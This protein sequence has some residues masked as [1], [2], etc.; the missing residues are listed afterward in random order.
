MGL[1]I[2]EI[3]RLASGFCPLKVAA[4]TVD[5]SN[6]EVVY[7]VR[8][9]LQNDNSLICV[10]TL[11]ILRALVILLSARVSLAFRVLP[12]D[13]VTMLC[14][15]E[16]GVRRGLSNGRDLGVYS[17]LLCS[18]SPSKIQRQV[19]FDFIRFRLLQALLVNH[20]T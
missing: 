5:L 17:L 6:T 14:T 7:N 10:L 12:W 4:I 16:D 1:L 3:P 8:G 20:P 19:V 15:V 18:F 13:A 9:F 11:T 2:P